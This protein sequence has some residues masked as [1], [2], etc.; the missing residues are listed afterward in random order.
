MSTFFTVAQLIIVISALIIL[1]EIGHYLGARLFKLDVEEFGIGIPPQ[2]LRFW[3]QKGRITIG[4]TPVILP[5]GNK[6]LVE[7]KDRMWVEALTKMDDD[8]THVLRK[9]QVLDPV[10]D[11][12]T[13][14]MEPGEDGSYKLR[15]YL[16]DVKQGT[17]FTLNWLPLGG[18]VKIK[19]EGDTNVADGLARANPWKRV[20][21][22][23][24]GPLMNLL[25]G[26]VLYA[27]I[28]SQLGMS[29]FSKVLIVEIAGG[30]PAEEAGLMVGDLLVDINGTNID[31]MNTI[32]KVVGD[33]LGE[34]IDVMVERQGEIQVISLIPRQ[35]PPEGQG[36]IGI[37]MGNPT[38]PVNWLQALPM[39]VTSTVN[40]S[41]ALVT[42]PAQVIRG[43]IPAEEAR[44]VG[45]KGMYDIYQDVQEREL[46]PGAPESL[47][48][49]WFFTTITISLG[50]LNLL[51][52]PALDGGRILFALPEILFRRRIPIEIQNLVNM[53]SFTIMILLFFY[54]NYLDFV[55]PVQLP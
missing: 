12:L 44:P 7:L 8:G 55:N 41:L 10:Q 23:A 36:A 19:G 22:Y 4:T 51:P 15:G 33:H 24:F 34:E 30:S 20:V 42:L 26:V 31:G 46:V 17:V 18:F 25:L 52:I 14:K 5:A 2:V 29:D 9:L 38:I 53:V 40:H 49:I 43:V 47:N 3:R 54:I 27:V 6:A 37:V 1:H 39:G 11:E 50:I 28:V 45:Y 35:K 32:H 48:I 16:S 21:V 13:Q